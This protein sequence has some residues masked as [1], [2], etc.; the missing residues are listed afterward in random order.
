MS[1]S[2][3]LDKRKIPTWAEMEFAR[4]QFFKPEEAVMQLHAPVEDYENGYMPGTEVLHLWRP[5]DRE[6]PLPPRSFV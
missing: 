6:I 3:A 4:R 5:T 1:V 2:I